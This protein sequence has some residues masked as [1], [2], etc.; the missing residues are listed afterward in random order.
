MVGL[1]VLPSSEQVEV[2]LLGTLSN[3]ALFLGPEGVGGGE[4]GCSTLSGL[5]QAVLGGAGG[6]FVLLVS[7]SR[8]FI[9][10]YFRTFYY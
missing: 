3:G 7:N 1:P 8:I 4:G 9:L 2:T 10:S 5:L 6:L